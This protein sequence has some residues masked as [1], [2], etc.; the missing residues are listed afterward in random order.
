MASASPD[1]CRRRIWRTHWVLRAGSL[2]T[3]VAWWLLTF[4]NLGFPLISTSP[5][6]VYILN[7]YN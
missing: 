2:T 5:E 4:I 1:V 6:T 7:S 3:A